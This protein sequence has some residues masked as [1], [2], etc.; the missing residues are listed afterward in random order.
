MSQ[1]AFWS[2]QSFLHSTR[3]SVPILYNGPPLFCQNCLFTW[4]S[5]PLGSA[6]TWFLGPSHVHHRSGISV[7]SA[8]F[9][10]LTIVTG[11][12]HY[13]ICNN[14]PH[15]HSASRALH[16]NNNKSICIASWGLKM[17]TCILCW[18][19]SVHWSKQIIETATFGICL[20]GPLFQSYA[21]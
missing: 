14:R 15:W 8:V 10:G 4:G 18:T 21:S 11:R 5:G 9:V 16:R 3:Q 19:W 1:M 7:S 13:S 17:L 6:N 20:T 12:P 2:V